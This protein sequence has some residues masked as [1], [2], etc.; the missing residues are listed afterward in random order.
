MAENFP[1]SSSDADVPLPTRKKVCRTAESSADFP[2]VSSHVQST[3]YQ[4]LSRLTAFHIWLTR[5]VF[6]TAVP[7]MHTHGMP[8]ASQTAFI[9]RLY[10]SQTAFL[11]TKA[12]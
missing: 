4:R 8:S 1:S 3:A 10:P 6:D 12:P 2:A 9:A 5:S 11:S 7:L